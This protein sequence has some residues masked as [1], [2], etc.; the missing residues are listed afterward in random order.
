M[1]TL[2]KKSKL[3]L[4]LKLEYSE[5]DYPIK[6]GAKTFPL[7]GDEFRRVIIKNQTETDPKQSEVTK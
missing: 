4:E 7:K 2:I 3:L 1:V 6:L 5:E